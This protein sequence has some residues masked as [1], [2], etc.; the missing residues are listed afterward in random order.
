MLPGGVVATVPFFHGEVLMVRFVT[1]CQW[2]VYICWGLVAPEPTAVPSSRRERDR[3]RKHAIQRAMARRNL[4]GWNL[5]RSTEQPDCLP[6]PKPF[7]ECVCEYN[8][9]NQPDIASTAKAK[10]RPVTVA[11][12]ATRRLADVGG[13]AGKIVTGCTRET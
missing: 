9:Q 3:P 4:R 7:K 6:T 2:P 8:A 5:C 1:P 10:I 13:Q 11:T 12:V